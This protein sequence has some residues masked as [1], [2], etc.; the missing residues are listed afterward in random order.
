MSAKQGQEDYRNI[1]RVIL[2]LVGL[3]A[4]SAL[5]VLFVLYFAELSPLFYIINIMISLAV[6]IHLV[7]RPIQVN[8]RLA[9]IM[10]I[11]LVPI[12][13]GLF[14]LV[15]GNNA[16]SR[17]R[18]RQ[19][20]VARR[21]RRAFAPGQILPIA[22]PDSRAAKRQVHYLMETTRYPLCR[23]SETHYLASGEDQFGVMLEAARGAKHFIFMEYFIIS[24]GEMWDEIF[25]IL[26]ERAAA[27]STAA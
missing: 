23:A 7:N 9:W 25:A 21:P 19:R 17:R 16:N 8:Y 10:L 11:A 24:E 27:A 1:V 5:F 4:Q 3:A 13:G 12:L 14:Y 2:T 20:L 26:S 6:M 15:Y 22:L 18:R